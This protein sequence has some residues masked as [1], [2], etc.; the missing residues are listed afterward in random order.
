MMGEEGK[1]SSSIKSPYVYSL[2][3][4]VHPG[5]RARQAHVWA[6]WPHLRAVALGLAASGLPLLGL[7]LLQGPFLLDAGADLLL[8]PAHLLLELT[9]EIYHTLGWGGAVE[10]KWRAVEEGNWWDGEK[11]KR[12]Y[13]GEFRGEENQTLTYLL[14]SSVFGN[15]CFQT[16]SPWLLAVNEETQNFP[17][18]AQNPPPK[19]SG[20]INI[21]GEMTAEEN[22][23]TVWWRTCWKVKGRHYQSTSQVTNGQK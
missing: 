1:M 19:T 23:S 15:A 7:P 6:G 21:N 18:H 9:D 22:M 8:K 3:S 17:E 20:N 11:I 14:I 2:S 16:V 10:G 5:V 12:K 13:E 4:I